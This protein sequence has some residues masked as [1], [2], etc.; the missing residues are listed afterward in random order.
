MMVKIC[1][2]TNRDDALAAVDAG[3]DALG[4]NFSD[5]ARAKNRYIEPAIAREIAAELPPTVL[6]VAVTVNAAANVLRNH[7]GFTDRVQLHGDE[8]PAFAAQFGDRAIKALRTGPDFT[9]ERVL[10]YAVGLIL[11]DAFVSGARGGTGERA[12]WNAARRTVALG[13]PILLAGGLTPEN[14]AE[15]VRIVRPFGVDV[16]GG[17]EKEP[18]KK[19]HERVRRFV[20]EAKLSLS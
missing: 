2:I 20:R 5:E 3:A 6:K 12:D 18:G 14:V 17:V 19:D 8:T 13:R 15:A 4:F 7:L 11:L 1:G 10:E 9:P 16:S